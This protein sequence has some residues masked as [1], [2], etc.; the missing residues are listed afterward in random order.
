MRG[1]G[2]EQLD[3]RRAKGRVSAKKGSRRPRGDLGLGVG[4]ARGGQRGEV[5]GGEW[6]PRSVA[7]GRPWRRK[8]GGT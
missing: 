5:R 8:G 6:R 7:D 4:S 2:N 1:G 3:Q